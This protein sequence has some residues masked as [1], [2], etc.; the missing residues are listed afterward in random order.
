[1][2]DGAGDSASQVAPP[3]D[4]DSDVET[5]L[6][7]MTQMVDILRRR[8][9][10]MELQQQQG[11]GRQDDPLQLKP[12]NAKDL[13]KPEKYDNELKKFNVW[14]ERL[15]DLLANR[16][17]TWKFLFK[18]IDKKGSERV[19]NSANFFVD[20]DAPPAAHAAMGAQVEVYQQQ[21]RT[22][23]RSYTGGELCARVQRRRTT[24]SWSCSGKLYGAARTRTPTSC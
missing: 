5:R 2:A 14:Y 19:R 22:Y 8:L 11:G 13:E 1:M 24:T 9:E 18:A 15:Q 6:E 21:L 4:D 23:L 7:N 17:S 16:S 3:S 10:A 20:M 12:I